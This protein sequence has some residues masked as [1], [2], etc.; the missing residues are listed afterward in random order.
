MV[1]SAHLLLTREIR[2]YREKFCFTRNVQNC[3]RKGFAHNRQN[4][5]LLE[6][7]FIYS[8]WPELGWGPD[9]VVLGKVLVFTEEAELR[10]YWKGLSV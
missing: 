4:C 1:L 7:G 9:C 5:V 10:S 3:L 2:S 6:N 8:E